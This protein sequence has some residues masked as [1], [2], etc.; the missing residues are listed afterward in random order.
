[1][2][3]IGGFMGF[4][5]ENVDFSVFEGVGA[6]KSRVGSLE[7]NGESVPRFLGTSLLKSQKSSL[8]PLSL[9]IIHP[10]PP[11]SGIFVGARVWRAFLPSKYFSIFIVKC[12]P[13]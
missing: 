13:I 9:L 2:G 1:M 7:A 3:A 6:L 11:A 5:D 10:F 12:Q 8:F 4:R